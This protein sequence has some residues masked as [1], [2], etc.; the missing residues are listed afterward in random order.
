VSWLQIE[1]LAN[2]ETLPEVEQ[3]LTA[4]GAVSITLVS[5]VHEPVLEPNPGET[6]LWSSVRVQALYPLD[7][8]MAEVRQGLAKLP[9]QWLAELEISFVGVEDWQN[10]LR[11][12]TVDHL[13]AGRLWLLPK[14]ADVAPSKV[15][16]GK[17]VV[18]LRLD[19]GLAFGSGSHP[20]TRLCLEWIARHV[21]AG[22]RV[23]DFGCGSGVLG[24]AAALLGAAV[25]AVDHDQQAIVATGENAAY[26]GLKAGEVVVL[27]TDDWR[28]DAH[29]A[30]FDVIVANI[31]AAP[32]KS[33]ALTFEQVAAPNAAIVLSGVLS[34]QVGEVIACYARTDFGPAEIED[35]WACLSGK[36][37]LAPM[38]TRPDA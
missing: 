22:D 29:A 34:E 18:E 35:G 1:L 26:N 38:S 6:P 13:F 4:C 25:V 17:N 19:P 33:L 21:N 5:D 9:S 27:S 7:V 14:D 36:R 37:Q 28:P 31:L 8:D 2:P 15:A 10:A 16:L 12:H 20:T 30:S 11:T 24:I 23:L 32:L 3:A